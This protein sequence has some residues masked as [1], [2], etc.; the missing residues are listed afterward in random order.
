MKAIILA[1]GRG[2]RLAPMTLIKPKPLLKINGKTLLENM[3]KIL[4][5]NGVDDI[6]VVT[7]YKHEMFDEYQEKLGFKKVVYDDYAVKNSSASLKLVIDEIV[8]G[9]IIFNGDLYLKNSFFSNIRSD[10]S[11]FLAQKIV[12][13]VTS[14]GYIVDRNFKLIDIDTNATSGYGDG[15]AIFDNEEDLKI[16]K[17][18]L[19]NTSDDEYWEYCVLRSIN[20]IN[21]YAFN[22]DDLYVE[23][24]SFRDALYHDLITPKEIAEQCSDNGNIEKLAGITNVNYKIKFLGED[25]VIRIPG[26]GTENIID[27]TSE[28][29]ILSLIYDKDIVPK[30]DFY[31]SDI[32]LT[33]FLYGYR[34]LD[35]EDL[36]N[37]DVIFPLIVEQMKKLHNISHEHHMDFKI[38]SMVEEIENYE[39]LSQIKIVNKSEHKFLLNLAR[40]MDKGKQVL[41]HRDLQLPNIMYNGE[42]IKFVD[43]EYAGFSSILWELGNF[44]AELEL[45]K[46]QIMK[47]IEIYKDITYEEIIIGQLMSNYIWALWGWIYDSIDLG[48]N[49]LSRFHSNINFLMKK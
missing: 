46:D 5:N 6:V 8:K 22:H 43:F 49:Y 4:K 44:T 1:A 47:F 12:D 42:R 14:W 11:Q 10:L 36:K 9:T 45:N 26:K 35:F 41:C 37:C 28:K 2:T 17:E 34:S 7:G 29:K 3:V 39:K 20:K 23:I 40:D 30:S 21:F 33:D 13:G 25:K 19:I 48:R 18:E 32:K 15:I 27:R 24:D 38:I 16:L 31:D